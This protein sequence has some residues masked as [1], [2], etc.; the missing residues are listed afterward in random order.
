[1]N[2]RD[3]GKRGELEFVNRLKEYGFTARRGVQYQGGPDSPDVVCPDLSQFHIEVKR[4]ERFNVYTALDQ[5]DL[6]RD[7]DQFPLVAHRKNRKQW[8]V[9]LYLDDFIHLLQN[10]LR[11]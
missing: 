7:I 4:T 8:V 2:S 6:D 10:D 1:M 11:K 5:A 3:K 9:A